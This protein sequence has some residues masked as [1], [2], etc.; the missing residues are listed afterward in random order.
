MTERGLRNT[1]NTFEHHRELS[2]KIP[3]KDGSMSERGHH[4][5]AYSD[6]LNNTSKVLPPFE[7]TK[8][9]IKNF[10]KITSFAVNTHKGCVRSYNED[11]V[12]ILLNAQQR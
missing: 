1:E 2:A 4:H 7:E 5:R 9:V 12:S 11:R 6:I 10:G 3:G 8:T